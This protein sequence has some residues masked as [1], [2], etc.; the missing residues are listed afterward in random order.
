MTYLPGLIIALAAFWAAL[1]GETAPMFVALGVAS[2]ALAL[3]L[4]GRLRVIGRDA[5]P[6]HRIVRLLVY[7]VWLLFEIFKANI[8]VIVRILSPGR[9]ID[10][11][12]VRLKAAG[13]SDLS[14]ALFANSITL[15]PG[16][17]TVDIEGD[18]LI[19]HVL[20][21]AN[22]SPAGFETMSF[23]SARTGDPGGAARKA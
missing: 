9:S 12:I 21:R 7:L 6:Y 16:T 22:A 13:A 19:V 5:S 18:R 3:L 14:R 8:A 15:T 4:A 1:S 11:D 10:P 20:A 23:F 17:V 2:V